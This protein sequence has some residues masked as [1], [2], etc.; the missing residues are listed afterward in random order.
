MNL[1]P[2][3]QSITSGWVEELNE[4]EFSG[5]LELIVLSVGI[6]IGSD[7]RVVASFPWPVRPQWDLC[8]SQEQSSNSCKNGGLKRESKRI[9]SD[10]NF[11]DQN[12]QLA[13]GADD[14]DFR[15]IYCGHMPRLNASPL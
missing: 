10:T 8:E 5:I 12:H 13:V 7:F 2:L 11:I 15:D 14:A 9:T 1:L 6:A 3:P 4:T